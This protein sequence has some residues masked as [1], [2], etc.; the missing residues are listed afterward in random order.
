LRKEFEIDL[1]LL[2]NVSYEESL[3]AKSE[4]DIYI[5]QLTNEGGWG[6]GMSAVEALSMGLPVV[7]NIPDKM[8]ARM[9]DHP[10]VHAIPETVESAQSYDVRSVGD[11]LYS[12]YERLGW[13]RRN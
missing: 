11:K 5:D 12:H 2:Q 13:L 8:A 3:R 7:S 10:F 6:Y 9:G 4:S 1:R